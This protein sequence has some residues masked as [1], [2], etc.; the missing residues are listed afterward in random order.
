VA[1]AAYG[2]GSRATA[3]R[4]AR[5]LI[6]SPISASSPTACTAVPRM[7]WPGDWSG[8]RVDGLGGTPDGCAGCARGSV[9][10]PGA[11][12]ARLVDRD[13]LL[14][15]GVVA[16]RGGVAARGE[17]AVRRGFAARD[18][19]PG[20]TLPFDR[21]F[22]GRPVSSTRAGADGVVF[23]AG[24]DGVALVVGADGVAFVA[25]AD[26]VAFVAGA[27]RFWLRRWGR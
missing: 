18:G 19:L 10:V 20:L 26:A 17:V 11:P 27:P 24:A 14:S 3:L 22:S 2:R 12:R 15:S 16:A 9:L 25:G 7:S 1:A 8:L 21:A 6:D 23:V 13:G 4:S 5:V